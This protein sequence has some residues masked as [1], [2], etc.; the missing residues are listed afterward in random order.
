MKQPKYW[1]SL[2]ND[3]TEKEGMRKERR[4]ERKTTPGR[5]RES[6]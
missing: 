2:H 1:D 6:R 4:R 5:E 3:R